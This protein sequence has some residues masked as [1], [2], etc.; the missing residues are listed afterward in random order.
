MM[1]NSAEKTADN[2]VDEMTDDEA[3]RMILA[4]GS[5]RRKE[6]LSGL[7]YDFEVIVPHVDES[8]SENETPAEHVVRLA[9]AKA[10]F[11]ARE[12]PDELVI[13]ADT[14]VV[15]GDQILGKPSSPAFAI[16]MLKKLS[17]KTHIVYTGLS[18]VNLSENI[19]KTDC[20]ST[21]VL[22][23]QLRDEDIRRYVNSGEPLDKAGAYG[24]QGMGSFLVK[25]YDGE[26]DTVIGFPTKLF[27]RL[28][29]EVTSWR[30]R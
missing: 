1:A 7:G 30:N 21:R 24:I 3:M 22:F 2:A 28:Y 15:L 14:I 25:S 29:E 8:Y 20:D 23:N 11:V 16:A 19:G 4:S 6:I 5:P 10:R 12:H 27:G 18:L 17:G 9:E 26:F 13:G